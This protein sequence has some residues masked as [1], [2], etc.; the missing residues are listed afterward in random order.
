MSVSNCFVIGLWML[1]LSV[2]SGEGDGILDL[3]FSKSG[4]YICSAPH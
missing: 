2:V 1:K 3:L 4:L